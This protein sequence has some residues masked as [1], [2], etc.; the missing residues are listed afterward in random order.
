MTR[1]GEPTVRNS[2]SDES[3]KQSSKRNNT[4]GVACW[5]L[6]KPPRLEEKRF[7]GRKVK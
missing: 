6:M 5:N 4:G 2:I 3:K 7:F 1:D